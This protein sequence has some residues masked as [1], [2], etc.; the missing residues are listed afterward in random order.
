M[1]TY[2]SK[3]LKHKLGDKTYSRTLEFSVKLT[4]IICTDFY[5]K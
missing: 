2:L 1:N 4:N 3:K 5:F